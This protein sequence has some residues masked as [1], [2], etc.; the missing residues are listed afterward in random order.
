MKVR[1]EIHEWSI[2]KFDRNKNTQKCHSTESKNRSNTPI[3]CSL[4]E[5]WP[6]DKW[7]TSSNKLD[8]LDLLFMK[9]YRIP[10]NCIDYHCNRKYKES[11][12]RKYSVL[13]CREEFHDER[14]SLEL[15]LVI[16]IFSIE[17]IFVIEKNLS[18]FW[19]Y[20]IKN[21]ILIQW[22]IVDAKRV[23]KRI[24]SGILYECG[25]IR[26]SQLQKI[27][28]IFLRD[29][30]DGD[31]RKCRLKR[32]GKST[33]ARVTRRIA[34][35]ETHRERYAIINSFDE[36]LWSIEYSKEDIHE[37]NKKSYYKN[38]WKG[39]EGIADNITKGVLEDAHGKKYLEHRVRIYARV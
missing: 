36:S 29:S 22:N 17:C 5:K 10:D 32:I 23:R 8:D 39:K 30:L 34:T 27:Q 11:Q 33:D 15:T 20:L 16:E 37:K 1:M 4:K 24:F 35:L 14:N 26:I 13:K 38:R 7:R 25:K 21:I 12:K 9:K 28:G 3:K 2:N 18:F 31:T 19:E 6:I